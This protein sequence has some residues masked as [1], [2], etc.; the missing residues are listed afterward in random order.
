MHPKVLSRDAWSIVRRLVEGGP[1][2]GWTLAGGT[3]L[4]LQLGHRHSEDLD[5]FRAGP[6]DV[7]RLLDQLSGVGT[8][9][10]Q[11]RSEHTLHVLLDGLRVSFLTAES[12]FLFPSIEYR[13]LSIAD[14]RDIA[15]LKVIAIGGRASRKDFVD[16]YF[17]LHNGVSLDSILALMQK[18]FTKIDYNAYHLLKSLTWFD[19]ADREPM[20]A[21]IR[22][23]E[24]H[25]VKNAIIAAVRAV[26]I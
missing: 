6:F 18:R 3:G 24:W 21:M 16:L 2:T 12:S 25:E 19:E 23:V 11:S 5:F 7:A 17:L 20:P 4:A 1:V 15:V 22:K 8:V 10:I 26:H 13:G 14:P 9:R